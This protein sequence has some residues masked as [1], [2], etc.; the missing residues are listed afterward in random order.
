MDLSFHTTWA[1]SICQNFILGNFFSLTQGLLAP[2][3]AL[4]GYGYS[5]ILAVAHVADFAKS[6][7]AYDQLSKA[8]SP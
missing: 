7:T 8:P 6:A 5:R 2:P 3:P 4:L 1:N